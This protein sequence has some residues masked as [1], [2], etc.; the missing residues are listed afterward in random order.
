[1][2]QTMKTTS[3]ATRSKGRELKDPFVLFKQAT[4][5]V[6]KFLEVYNFEHVS[7][8]DHAP[9]CEIKYQNET[10]GVTITYEWGGVAW[11]ELSRLKRKRAGVVEDGT[12]SVDIL[13]LECCPEWDINDF[14]PSENESPSQY[15]KRVLQDYAE[16][17]KE[18]GHE[19]LKGDFQIFPKLK[20]HAEDVLRQKNKE[21][22]ALTP[23]S[24][25]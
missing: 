15:V 14:Y 8:S 21:L 7:T 24:S 25:K 10:T 6:F 9:E 12:Y 1:M 19:I 22:F 16:V 5:E 23:E 2:D 4:A 3:K 17:L 11:V 18:C 20:K 13:I